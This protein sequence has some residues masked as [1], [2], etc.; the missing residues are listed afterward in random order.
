MGGIMAVFSHVINQCKKYAGYVKIKKDGRAMGT[1]GNNKNLTSNLN[2][3]YG[4]AGMQRL[5]SKSLSSPKY[6]EPVMVLYLLTLIGFA[7]INK[8]RIPN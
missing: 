5:K 2:I 4:G 1:A 3:Y 6:G 8:F 7:E